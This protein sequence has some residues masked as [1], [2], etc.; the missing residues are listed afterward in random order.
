MDEPT[1]AVKVDH[2]Y[3]A[4][5]SA[6]GVHRE[7][8]AHRGERTRPR[9]RRGTRRPGGHRVDGRGGRGEAQNAALTPVE[10]DAYRMAFEWPA[11]LSELESGAALTLTF[12]LHGG[13]KGS[14]AQVVVK[15]LTLK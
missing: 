2:V 5:S 11:S 12:T 3:A 10:S 4:G 13:V 14:P 7:V 1:E 6:D 9:V 15:K 8:Q